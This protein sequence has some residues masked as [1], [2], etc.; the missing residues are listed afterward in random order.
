MPVFSFVAFLHPAVY[1]PQTAYVGLMPD[2][3]SSDCSFPETWPFSFHLEGGRKA[4]LG[5]WTR[6]EASEEWHFPRLLGDRGHWADVS[7]CLPRVLY[8][9]SLT[10][11]TRSE[12]DK[13]GLGFRRSCDG[14]WIFSSCVFNRCSRDSPSSGLTGV[15]LK[16]ERCFCGSDHG[17]SGFVI[18]CSSITEAIR[19]TS[20]I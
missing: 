19:G 11:V 10:N 18:L 13:P 2:C 5:E 4:C 7:P 15:S 20:E 12:R 6:G 14:N 9:A 8:R 17:F 3:F 1:V 16:P